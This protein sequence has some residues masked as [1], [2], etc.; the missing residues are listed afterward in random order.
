MPLIVFFVIGDF[1][2]Y[3]STHFPGGFESFLNTIIALMLLG[4]FALVYISN[5]MKN[6]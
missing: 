3:I 6:K 4:F 5:Y 2:T 1:I